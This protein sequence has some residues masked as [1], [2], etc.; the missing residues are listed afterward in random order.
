[1]IVIIGLTLTEVGRRLAS[2]T[3]RPG[4]PRTVPSGSVTLSAGSAPIRA[5]DIGWKASRRRSAGFSSI[6][7]KSARSPRGMTEQWPTFG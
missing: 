7:S 3:Y 1:M 4:V 2:A 5:V 6:A